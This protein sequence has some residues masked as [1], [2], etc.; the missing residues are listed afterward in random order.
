[1]KVPNATF[2]AL[3]LAKHPDKTFIGRVEKGFALRDS[4]ITPQALSV[5]PAGMC[6]GKVGSRGG[7]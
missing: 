4:H 5:A 7:L 1:M 3:G 2:D 6:T